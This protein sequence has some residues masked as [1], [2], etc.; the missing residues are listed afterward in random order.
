M[1]YGPL[2]SAMRS[3]F[4]AAVVTPPDLPNLVLWL[5]A[6]VGTY[7]DTG[8]TTPATA[9]GD[10]VRLWQDQS[11][12]GHHA[13][14]PS[15]P[16]RPTLKTSVVNGK[17]AHRFV[18]TDDTCLKIASW[19]TSSYNASITVFAIT[20]NQVSSG[21][22]QILH[23]PLSG[24]A[25]F[26]LLGQNA[27]DF[28]T[29]L[30]GWSP[31]TEIRWNAANRLTFFSTFSHNQVIDKHL[32]NGVYF[33]QANT[34]AV[35]FSSKDLWIGQNESANTA[36]GY[37]GD[38]LELGLYHS[39]LTK[40]NMLDLQSYASAKYGFVPATR[41]V[42]F[43]GDSRTS[44]YKSTGGMTYPK[45][46]GDAYSEAFYHWNLGVYGSSI[47]TMASRASDSVSYCDNT[48]IY[49]TTADCKAII[50]ILCGIND[51][52]GDASSSTIITNLSNYCLARRSAGFKV[53]LCTI[54]T[55]QYTTGG[56]AT[57][58]NAV[59]ADIVSNGPS[60]YCD[61]VANLAGDSRLQNPADGVYYDVDQLH[62][63]NAGYGVIA[64]LVKPAIDSLG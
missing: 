15:D 39:I 21:Q 14:A 56:R 47:V 23:Y 35:E 42:I 25:P 45:Q 24:A 12:Q 1:A 13:I 8:A 34:G 7:Q 48:A 51:V 59:N 27:K 38:L 2:V 16:R 5:K 31:G 44:G 37:S 6:G 36:S 33:S 54:P 26:L 53:V 22:G 28:Y 62:F 18:N 55:S 41:R 9:D 64:S 58:L 50:C 52:N 11:G 4:A 29:Y 57:V 20:T 10:K 19:P 63:T 61:A 17:P 49:N 32:V 46:V 30:S 60:T 3:H 40:Q 43:E